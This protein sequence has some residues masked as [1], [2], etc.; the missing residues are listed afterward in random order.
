MKPPSRS[1]A[2]PPARS[3]GSL[4]GGRGHSTR[5]RYSTRSETTE[6]SRLDCPRLSGLCGSSSG[7]TS[8]VN[9]GS[10][11]SLTRPWR[12]NLDSRNGTPKTRLPL[13]L[14]RAFS[15]SFNAVPQ[16]AGCPTFIGSFLHLVEIHLV[17]C[18]SKRGAIYDKRGA[19]QCTLSASFPTGR[20]SNLP[21][22]G[23]DQHEETSCGRSLCPDGQ[24]PPRPSGKEETGPFLKGFPLGG[25]CTK[26]RYHY[27][28]DADQARRKLEASG[29][30]GG[31]VQWCDR[32][33]AFHVEQKYVP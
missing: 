9:P 6:R 27:P 20:F 30:P 7:R 31:I 13:S 33:G 29:K 26:P 5:L 25:K 19:P 21:R 18:S 10:R 23:K 24:G 28:R 2:S 22:T 15:R 1:P 17:R 32:C 4:R 14:R 8:T 12:K 3:R 16:P 11:G